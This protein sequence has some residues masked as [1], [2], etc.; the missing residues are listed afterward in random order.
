MLG[1]VSSDAVSR[2]LALP[3]VEAAMDDA[4]QACTRLRWHPA[5]RRRTDQAR[6]EA[7]V[8]AIRCSAALSGAR[9]PPSVVRD[10]LR[11]AAPFPDDA[12]GLT[13]H[14]TARAHVEAQGLSG[15]WQRAPMQAIARLHTA[16]AAGLLPQEA[17]GR[18][19]RN[20]EA[21]GDGRDLLDADG[22]VV[23]APSAQALTQRLADLADLLTGS[24][25]SPALIVA[26]VA[27]A[28]LAVMRPFVAANAVVA[29]A[30]C[31]AVVVDRGLDPTGV[32][33]WEAALLSIGPAYP[34]A[35]ASY[36]VGG[37]EGVAHWLRTFA[38]AVVDGAQEGHAVCDAV[39]A[40][41]LPHS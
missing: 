20:D 4:R 26:A 9:V 8:R 7:G 25:P 13:V 30:L 17:L 2:L 34:L 5:L 36:E 16:G 32:V 37:A 40:G 28:E 38:Q 27:H 14:G 24:A 3:G 21:P 41:T 33:V 22:A 19:R 1:A 35:L 29:R 15:T 18:P 39:V 31:R 12:A 6:A 10:A 23:P 11:G